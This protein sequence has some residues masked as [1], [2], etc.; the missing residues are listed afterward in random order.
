M[1]ST[2]RFFGLLLVLSFCNFNF[3]MRHFLFLKTVI[4]KGI[5][6]LFCSS[7]FLVGNNEEV[8]GYIMMGALLTLGLLFILIGCSCVKMHYDEKD[9]T[10]DD[11][12]NLA[13]GSGGD[14][15]AELLQDNV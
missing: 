5:F 15:K 12:K 6:C 7:M 10:K 8:W 14:E 1:L 9:L 4:G 2:C 3:V 11:A 13:K